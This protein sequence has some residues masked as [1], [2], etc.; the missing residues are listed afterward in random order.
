MSL[1]LLKIAFGALLISIYCF[2]RYAII[3]PLVTWALGP[4]T[5]QQA[6]I[7]YG[8]VLWLVVKT[9]ASETRSIEYVCEGDGAPRVDGSTE[10]LPGL[11]DADDD[12]G[13]GLGQ[14]DDPVR[15]LSIH[16]WTARFTSTPDPQRRQ[17]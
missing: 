9:W 13:A 8:F 11:S 16:H 3:P 12:H 15:D 6:V 2:W 1:E 5:W 7:V 4:E 17:T 14:S 10:S